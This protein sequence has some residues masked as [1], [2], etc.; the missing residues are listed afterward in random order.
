MHILHIETGKHLYGGALQV[1]YLLEGLKSKGCDNSLVCPSGSSIGKKSRNY[2][3]TYEVPV[4]GELDPAF[5]FRLWRIVKKTKPDIIHVHSRRG[6]DLWGGLAALMT[7]TKAVVTR[8][9]DNPEQ[10]WLARIKYRLYDRVIVISKGIRSV[11]LAEGVPAKK[12]IYIPSGIK[13]SQYKRPCEKDWFV[14]EFALNTNNQIIGFVGQFIE[15][16]GHRY[17][18]EAAPSIIERFPY[19]HFLFLGQ[20]P[21]EEKLKALCREKHIWNYFSFTGFRGDIP[22]ILPCLDLLIHPA[23][24]E[25][26]GVSLLQAAAAAIP[27][28]AGGVGGVP[29]IVQNGVN[30]YL[31][32]PQSTGEIIDSTCDLLSDREK[33]RRFGRSGSKIVSSSFSL[34]KTIEG[35]FSVYQELLSKNKSITKRRA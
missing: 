25:G 14:R 30:G 15:R 2:A 1:L 24:M 17:L 12:L 27:I 32:N 11:L 8:R 34:P 16:K 21:L 31:I 10:A 9:V 3:D 5:G 22:R 23:E 6:A 33:M 7:K 19:V 35:N 26:L 18:I 29:E 4:R 13:V 20:G 28:I